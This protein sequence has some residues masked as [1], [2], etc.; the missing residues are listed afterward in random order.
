MDQNFSYHDAPKSDTA[1]FA[2]NSRGL[3]HPPP[4]PDKPKTDSKH[5][6]FSFASSMERAREEKVYFG[7]GGAAKEP[8]EGTNYQDS[9]D[10]R[11]A[12]AAAFD[13]RPIQSQDLSSSSTDLSNSTEH[14]G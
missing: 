8:A 9:R 10:C 6:K 5:N 14:K 4:E 7:N 1:P 11:T 13:E 2:L 3:D 12:A